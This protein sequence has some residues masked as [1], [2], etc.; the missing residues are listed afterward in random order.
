MILGIITGLI[1]ITVLVVIV[2]IGFQ[3]FLILLLLIP[4]FY[5][6][7][8]Y[9]SRKTSKGRIKRDA[10]SLEKT[11]FRPLLRDVLVIDTPI[12]LN[13]KYA[14][15][16]NALSIVLAANN[17]KHL[18][19]DEQRDE[20]MMTAQQTFESAGQSKAVHDAK[21]PLKQFMDN[22]LITRAPLDSSNEIAD[23]LLS[24]KLLVCAAKKSRNVTLISDNREFIDRARAVL[25]TKKIGLTVID[26]LEELIPG[27]HDYCRAVREGTIKPTTWKRI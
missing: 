20:I 27:C 8:M 23:E 7:G 11:V 25:K 16:F 21:S 4:F 3:P 9:R 13:E 22:N 17:K 14:G 5:L 19:F 18:L 26:Y 2:S 6:A 1:L 10:R 15:F 12:W 24:V